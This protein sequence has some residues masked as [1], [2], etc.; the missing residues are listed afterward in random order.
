MSAYYPP[1]LE[2]VFVTLAPNAIS[3]SDVFG[4]DTPRHAYRYS[5]IA[6]MATEYVTDGPAALLR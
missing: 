3:I 2:S 4:L 6:E 5:E 1:I